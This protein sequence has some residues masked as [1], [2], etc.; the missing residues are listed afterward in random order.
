MSPKIL[1]LISQRPGRTG[2]G[3]ILDSMVRCAGRAR[4]TQAVA[5]GTPAEDLLPEVGGLATESIHP[6]IFENGDL[7]FPVPGMSDVMPYPS[8]QFSLMNSD[9]LDRY[10]LAWREHLTTV[11]KSFQPDLI[12]S[13]HLWILSSMVKD[14]APGI[15]Q[16]IQCHATGFRQM[17][18][19]PH[20]AEE[21][22]TG[23]ARAD[24]FQ[25]LSEEHA[26]RLA[27][28][29]GGNPDRI[30]VLP[31]GYREDL[32]HRRGRSGDNSNRILYVGKL[33]HA[34][35][36]PWLLDAFDRLRVDHP[37]IELH[38]AGSGA[39]PETD[40]LERRL[41]GMRGAVYHGMVD[42]SALGALMRKAEICVLP[43]FYEGVPMV[44]IEALACGCK[45][46]S[47]D[48][49]GVR[50]RIAPVAASALISVK[51][52][53]LLGIDEPLGEDLPQ[54]V[55]DLARAISRALDAPTP[56]PVDLSEFDGKTA[57]RKTEAIWRK[58]LG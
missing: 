25:V 15:P 49:P 18:L 14:L 45:L 1:H 16:V 48:L 54:F 57:F 23:C 22:K 58:L 40:N 26:R 31:S 53:R 3:V 8:T 42:Q 35:G 38:V 24:H 56:E 50:D 39:G 44:L 21:V 51:L 33:S 36:L 11:I 7:D 52:P 20:L 6:L 46:I 19:C 43:S 9:L 2:S 27:D 4:W 41:R 28:E 55:E 30:D 12:H 10:R 29:L 13:H 5:L 17:E 47:T 32:F 37:A 34:K